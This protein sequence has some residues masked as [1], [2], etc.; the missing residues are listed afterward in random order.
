MSINT[1]KHWVLRDT[2]ISLM[3]M[4]LS[5]VENA[6]ILYVCTSGEKNNGINE[7]Y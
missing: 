6:W 1:E 7:H 3:C 5:V 4:E 2:L